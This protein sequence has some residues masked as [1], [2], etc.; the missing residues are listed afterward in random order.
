MI[1]Y[2]HPVHQDIFLFTNETTLYDFIERGQVESPA[3]NPLITI[4][5][6]S[7]DDH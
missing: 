2:Q 6:E 4:L 1:G 7:V 5:S 3:L